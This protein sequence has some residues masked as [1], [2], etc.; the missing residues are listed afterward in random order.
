MLVDTL[1]TLLV[2]VMLGYFLER[3]VCS[4]MRGRP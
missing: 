3:V 4:L 2:D 1:V